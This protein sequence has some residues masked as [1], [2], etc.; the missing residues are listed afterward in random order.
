[1]TEQKPMRRARASLRYTIDSYLVKGWEIVSRNPLTL[2][3]GR[4]RIQLVNGVLNHG[5]G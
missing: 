4:G 5:R 2:K 3:L 1:M